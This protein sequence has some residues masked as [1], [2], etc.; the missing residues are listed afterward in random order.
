[1]L[2]HTGSGF[3][4]LAGKVSGNH[5]ASFSFMDDFASGLALF[6]LAIAR[7]TPPFAMTVAD[8]SVIEAADLA[9]YLILRLERMTAPE[10]EECL[11]D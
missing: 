3:L 10:D 4:L 6:T 1:M 8:F 2:S 11:L 9:E 7:R 5:S